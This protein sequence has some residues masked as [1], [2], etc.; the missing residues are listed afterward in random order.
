MKTKHFRLEEL[1]APEIFAAR[2]QRAWELLRPDML[3]MLDL[4]RERH[5]PIIINDYLWS[6]PYKESGLRL[7]NTA[8]GA[9]WSMHKFGGAFDLKFESRTTDEVFADLKAHPEIY[10]AVTTVEN[11]NATRGNTKDWLHV[12][13]RNSGRPDLWVVNP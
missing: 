9:Q 2:G 4:F 13:C 7:P 11:I 5:G 1:V 10:T 12:D 8:T 6:G 3:P